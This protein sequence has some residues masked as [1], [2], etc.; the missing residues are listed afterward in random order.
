MS[1][2]SEKIV[3]LEVPAPKHRG[4]P[5]GSKNKVGN[6]GAILDLV[7]E[8]ISFRLAIDGNPD[9]VEVSLRRWNVTG[10]SELPAGGTSVITNVGA[11]Q[12]LILTAITE[13]AKMKDLLGIS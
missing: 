11:Q 4:R 10:I 8:W 6:D 13:Y 3:E 9:G 1:D 5:K 12:P 2:L 7:S